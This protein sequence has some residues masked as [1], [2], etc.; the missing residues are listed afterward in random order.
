M[1]KKEELDASIR[2][3]FSVGWGWGD[4]PNTDDLVNEFEIT[5]SEK[6]G[7]IFSLGIDEDVI[8]D[9]A[10]R[11]F[12]EYLVSEKC[13]LYVFGDDDEVIVKIGPFEA[14]LSRSEVRSVA[15]FKPSF[16]REVKCLEKPVEF[17]GTW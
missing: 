15:D 2:D 11:Q 9:E 7:M 5:R 8:A 4:L 17:D 16:D 10:G 3:F 6:N 12:S 1:Q 14:R 13:K